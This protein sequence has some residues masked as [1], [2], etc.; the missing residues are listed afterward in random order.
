M[1]RRYGKP[2]VSVL[3]GVAFALYLAL[4]PASPGGAG[5]T[6]I[7]AVLIATA[8]AQAFGTY[9]VP[10]A[11]SAPWGKTAVGAVL[12]GLAVAVTVLGD[13]WQAQQDIFIIA[14]EVAAALGITIAPAISDNGARARTGLGDTPRAGGTYGYDR[15]SVRVAFSLAAGAIV[16]SV[17]ILAVAVMAIRPAD[18]ANKPRP[19]ACDNSTP[20]QAA[21]PVPVTPTAAR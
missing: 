11:A 7:E 12:A 2:I 10:L 1:F 9:I 6:A 16:A 20:T 3:V 15:G 17:V 5:I 13:G 8:L 19:P 21:H 4:G 14:F 18:A